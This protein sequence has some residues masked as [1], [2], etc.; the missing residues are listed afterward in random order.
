MC[1]IEKTKQP[2]FSDLVL[3]ASKGQTC[4]GPATQLIGVPQFSVIEDKP[5][6]PDRC[7]DQD[8]ALPMRAPTA[9]RSFSQDAP[10]ANGM[11]QSAVVRSSAGPIATKEAVR[12]LVPDLETAEPAHTPLLIVSASFQGH[13]PAT[14]TSPAKEAS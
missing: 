12:A 11:D 10:A 5:L 3:L 4:L 6:G 14:D 8:L 9:Q 1:W 7:L 2:A 13:R